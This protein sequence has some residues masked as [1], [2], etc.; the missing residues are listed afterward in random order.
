MRPPGSSSL[1]RLATARLLNGGPEACE[2]VERDAVDAIKKA[3]WT[4]A[5]QLL[6]LR[7]RMHLAPTKGERAS[8]DRIL[9]LIDHAEAMGS[10][11]T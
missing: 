4:R 9:R 8:I 2:R 1:G 5:R 7:V 10:G 11:S 6:H 3:E